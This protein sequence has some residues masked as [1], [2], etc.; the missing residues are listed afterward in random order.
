MLTNAKGDE[1]ARSNVRDHVRWAFRKERH[2][3]QDKQWY[4]HG[5]S[6]SLGRYGSRDLGRRT[7]SCHERDPLLEIFIIELHLFHCKCVEFVVLT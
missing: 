3:G 7:V 1:H 2:Y 6:Q 5:V 4:R